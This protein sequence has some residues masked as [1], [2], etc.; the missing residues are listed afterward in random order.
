V[1]RKIGLRLSALRRRKN[2]I[3]VD[4]DPQTGGTAPGFSLSHLQR[5]T[6][7]PHGLRRP[8]TV[9]ASSLPFPPGEWVLGVE[10]SGESRAYPIASLWKHHTIND[11]VGGAPLLVSFCRKCFGGVGFDPRVDG[12]LLTFE[13]FGA[14]QGS[15]VL[16]DDQSHSLWASL[17][18]VALAGSM[19][20]SR[21][22]LAPLRLT[23]LGQWLA[24]HPDSSAP[25]PTGMVRPVRW[26]PGTYGFGR[27][28]RMT[29][30][31]WDDRLPERTLVLGV[32]AGSAARAYALSV[33]DPG[34]RL[35]NDELGGIP[36]VLLAP[37]G[38]WPLAFDRR[39]GGRVA[40]LRVDGDR[41]VDE[42]GS[43]WTEDG[44]ASDATA[45]TPSLT[46]LPSRIAEWYA[47]AAIRPDT[48][49]VQPL[50]VASAVER[51]DVS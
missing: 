2:P 36:M 27:S 16:A 10:W 38:A 17:T 48:D 24:A 33:Q 18:G 3:L 29:V 26:P 51:D 37:P 11:E 32:E 21:L 41:I 50:R 15:V 1:N 7:P 13:V 44:R 9:P 35:Y 30:S 22:D 39:V 40:T 5:R 34:P 20:G 45:P 14:Y 25:D 46:F 28:W 31:R 4:A 6:I 49:V 8:P 12:R 42:R 43:V 23:T 19:I 47:W